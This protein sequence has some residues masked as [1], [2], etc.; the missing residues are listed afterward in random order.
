MHAVSPGP[1]LKVSWLSIV[2]CARS[3]REPN[4]KASL[5]IEAELGFEALHQL[6]VEF[7]CIQLWHGFPVQYLAKSI[8][9]SVACALPYVDHFKTYLF[10]PMSTS[11]HS[12]S[13]WIQIERQSCHH[14]QI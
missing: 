13:N 4:Y 7:S 2:A 14:L 5:R 6:R 8:A 3:I 9:R 10:K 1:R 12:T 11:S